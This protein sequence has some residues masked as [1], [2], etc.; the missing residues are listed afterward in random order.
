MGVRATTVAKSAGIGRDSRSPRSAREPAPPMH[1]AR[2][3]FCTHPVARF[4]KYSFAA[5]HETIPSGH[6]M[7]KGKR[8]KRGAKSRRTSAPGETVYAYSPLDT[9]T[10]R[11]LELLPGVGDEPLVCNLVTVRLAEGPVYEAMSY[12]WGP[13]QP[14]ELIG[15]PE[16]G[17]HITGN[18]ADGLRRVRNAGTPRMLWVDQVCINQA[19]RAE[20]AAQVGIMGW[21]FAEARCVIMWLGVDKLQDPQA[22]SC[23]GL[24]TRLARLSS[25]SEDTS[26]LRYGHVWDDILAMYG[27]P[28]ARDPQ[29]KALQRLHSSPYFSRLWIYQEVV[30]AASRV[31]LWGDL[32]LDYSDMM[33]S[34]QFVQ[35]NEVLS[36]ME[37]G[38]RTLV[39]R[40]T[41]WPPDGR[42]FGLFQLLKWTRGL[43][44]SNFSDRVYAV[45]GLLEGPVPEFLEP[46]Y[47]QDVLLVYRSAALHIL[48]TTGKLDFLAEVTAS[49]E[50]SD[51]SFPWPTWVPS[52]YDALSNSLVSDSEFGADCGEMADTTLASQSAAQGNLQ[53]KGMRACTITHVGPAWDGIWTLLTSWKLCREHL[54]A[55]RDWRELTETFLSMHLLCDDDGADVRPK[56][57]P[58]MFSITAMLMARY[59]TA[60]LVYGDVGV[61]RVEAD[62]DLAYLA[63]AVH[64]HHNSSKLKSN[65]PEWRVTGSP[66][67]NEHVTPDAAST[68]SRAEPGRLVPNEQDSHHVART[69]ETEQTDVGRVA[70]EWRTKYLLH[71]RGAVTFESTVA[72]VRADIAGAVPNAV[73]L[74]HVAESLAVLITQ[75][76]AVAS[77]NGHSDH[78]NRLLWTSLHRR[79]FITDQGTMGIGREDLHVGDTVAVLFGSRTPV[80]LRDTLD[81]H[82]MF[83]GDCYLEGVME[84]QYVQDLQ[85][86][87]MLQSRT[88]RFVLD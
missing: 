68:E 67:A 56:P 77:V 1:R 31:V 87:G 72:K 58:D 39:A 10:I 64:A 65:T 20:R 22:H 26:S 11:L 86:R 15:C 62:L 16:A 88:E 36:Q 3:W 29:W 84:G 47:S 38:G 82:V 7:A 55:R 8:L 21:I 73:Q 48:L 44:C 53:L 30:S 46:N 60:V 43:S 78:T 5:V 9:G 14:F 24:V 35:R 49:Q 6:M 59:Y 34:L 32:E 33:A 25:E 70:R 81:G 19:D 50:Q 54:G 18:L 57:L 41:H 52:W 37:G 79:F 66:Y 76:G 63:A 17:V 51:A 42:R 80:I 61:T 23:T 74:Q 28:M 75:C 12:V 40:A 45:L 71:A 27:L 69:S 2:T 85:G 13:R 4:A 83:R